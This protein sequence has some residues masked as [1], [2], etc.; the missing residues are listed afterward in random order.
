MST[1]DLQSTG[2]IT[3]DPSYSFGLIKTAS[4][5]VTY[6][7]SDY[8]SIVAKHITESFDLNAG[9]SKKLLYLKEFNIPAGVTAELR[10]KIY[11][12]VSPA[13][14][15]SGNRVYFRIRKVSDDTIVD[16]KYIDTPSGEEF[17]FLDELTTPTTEDVYIEVQAVNN[18]HIIKEVKLFTELSLTAYH[19]GSLER[20]SSI[21]MSVKAYDED[22]TTLLTTYEFTAI[23]SPY[24]FTTH[25]FK[26]TY[27]AGVEITYE[28]K[29]G[30]WSL[31]A[32]VS[33]VYARFRI[34]GVKVGD[35]S[36]G[37]SDLPN[38]FDKLGVGISHKDEYGDIVA[39][40]S[41]T[42]PDIDTLPKDSLDETLP[43]G[44]SG[45][46]VLWLNIAP[47]RIPEFVGKRI[48]ITTSLWVVM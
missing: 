38:Y 21:S 18:R 1:T 8:P 33:G 30:T 45:D 28:M 31:K 24:D 43:D 9:S 27:R 12:R 5:T 26:G 34:E 4:K 25:H 17:T 13:V 22:G 47:K 10:V 16:E 39:F 6:P 41:L 44:K 36:L 20:G 14:F 37:A 11:A 7:E 42:L 19:D 29:V 32:G 40:P 48:T 15:E 3:L 23:V 35:T 46:C 2:E